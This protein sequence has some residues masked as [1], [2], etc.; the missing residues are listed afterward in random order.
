MGR[1]LVQVTLKSVHVGLPAPCGVE[2]VP[3][4]HSAHS[5]HPFIPVF[6]ML[7]PLKSHVRGLFF[8]ESEY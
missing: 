2:T 8:L 3:C 6:Y 5:H 4:T 1:K 7:L